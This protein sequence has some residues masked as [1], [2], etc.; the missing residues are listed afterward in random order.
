MHSL[1]VII[2]AKNE[3]DNI[4]RVIEDVLR[5]APP[6]QIIV[7]DDHS[8]DGTGQK[9]RQHANVTVLSA[10]ISLG[11]GGAVQL[12]VLYGLEKGFDTFVRMDGDGQHNALYIKNLLSKTNDSTLV[13]GTRSPADFKASSSLVRKFG[14]WYFKLLFRVFARR[15]IDDP[16]SGFICFP[17]EIAENFARYYPLDYPEIESTVLLLRA[18]YNV[19]C[20]EVRMNPRKQGNSSIGMVY[21][22]IYMVAVSF[23]FFISFFKKNPYEARA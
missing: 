8:T 14:S 10:S 12:G 22:F 19:V 5:N 11:I 23:A 15:T 17:R 4:G 16:T 1:A 18:G 6:C 20:E 3:A 2:P 13:V 21:S 7:V 9:A